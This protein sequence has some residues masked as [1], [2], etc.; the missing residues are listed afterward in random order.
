MSASPQPTSSTRSSRRAARR[1]KKRDKHAR[2]KNIRNNYQRHID[3]FNDQIWIPDNVS[4][5]NIQP[6]NYYFDIQR[7][8]NPEGYACI[9]PYIELDKEVDEKIKKGKL[10]Q[11]I[12]VKMFPNLEQRSILDRWF[13]AFSH[14]Y[15]ETLKFIKQQYATNGT[16]SLSYKKLRTNHLKAIRDNIINR[17]QHPNIARDT[18]VKTHMLDAAIKLACANYK[19]AI[20]N[21]KR[22][23]IRHFRIR[24]WRIN[25]SVKVIEIEKQYFTGNSICPT[26]LGQLYCEYDGSQFNLSDIKNHYKMSCNIHY[27]KQKNEYILLVPYKVTQIIGRNKNERKFIS[28]DPG[29]KTFMTG[30]SKKEVIK[31]G[32]NVADKIK[33]YV[34]KID[35]AKELNDRTIYG[36]RALSNRKYKKIQERCNRKIS[37]LVDELHWKTINFLITRYKTIVIGDMSAKSIVSKETSVLKRLTKIAALRMKFYQFR[38]RLKYKCVLKKIDFK[39]V[40][41]MYTSKVCSCCGYY[42]KKLGGSRVYNCPQCGISMDRDVNGAR[43]ILIKSAVAN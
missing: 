28:L 37:N 40:N 33:S 14:M 4:G 19:S 39:V 30:L 43:G 17:S 32:T 8:A 5:V 10:R 34:V 9:E 38:E 2:F 1:R 25:R 42:N 6:D 12:K 36:N 22:G 27:D 35:K 20:T 13:D 15:N 29:I 11:A 23:N 31:I 26:V 21:L 7:Y 18:K 41:E 24:Y 16:V 3:M